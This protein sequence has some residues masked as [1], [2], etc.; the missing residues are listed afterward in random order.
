[1]AATAKDH[2]LI[3]VRSVVEKEI[4]H[5]EILRVMAESELLQK[6]VFIGGT[7]LRTCYASPRLSESSP[8]C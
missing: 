1:M 4:L 2:S 5:Q 8:V 3:P 6:L 7:C